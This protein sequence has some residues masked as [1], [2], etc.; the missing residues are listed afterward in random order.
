MPACDIEDQFIA[1]NFDAAGPMA[2]P[3]AADEEDHFAA[4]GERGPMQ[5]LK[6]RAWGP[7]VGGV[8]FDGRE[9]CLPLAVFKKVNRMRPAVGAFLEDDSEVAGGE[10]RSK[11]QYRNSSVHRTHSRGPLGLR[12]N[13]I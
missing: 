8:T 1:S 4:V 2:R 7:F 11:F 12:L 10:G 13:E 6:G 9:R 5:F 3:R